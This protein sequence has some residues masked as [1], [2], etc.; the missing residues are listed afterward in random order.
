MENYKIVLASSSP[1][2]IE[3]LKKNGIDPIIIPPDT[4]EALPINIDPKDAVMRLALKKAQCV[5]PAAIALCKKEPLLIIGADTIVFLERIIGKPKN[6]EEA[7]KTL[8]HLRGREHFVATGV[9][10]LSAGTDKKRVF[11]ETTRVC[12]KYYSDA[13]IMAYIQTEEPYDKAG[14]Y[15]IQGAWGEKVERISGDYDN[16]MGFPW[17]RIKLELSQF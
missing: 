9:A 3:I 13:D 6:R 16:V 10:I 12:F 5:E 14:G 2:R 8:E 15:A 1:R 11:C 17:A 4:D 7:Y